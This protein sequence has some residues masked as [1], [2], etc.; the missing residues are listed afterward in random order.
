MFGTG[1]FEKHQESFITLNNIFSQN[2]LDGKTK[3]TTFFASLKIINH[4]T[5]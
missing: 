2:I 3:I 5:F 1:S 4:G